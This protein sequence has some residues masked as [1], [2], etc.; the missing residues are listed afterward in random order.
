MS[1]STFKELR[2]AGEDEGSETGFM[3]RYGSC[4][5][6]P[7][8]PW[9]PATARELEYVYED[10][11]MHHRVG[12]FQVYYREPYKLN[13]DIAVAEATE[14]DHPTHYTSHPSG[15]ECIEITEHMNFNLGN[16]MKY[17]WRAGLKGKR[18]TDLKKA[19]FYINREIARIQG[20][21][22]G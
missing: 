20:A 8:G 5:K 14:V 3:V 9:V 6:K 1:L 21:N 15:V 17:I 22:N 19:I 18:L 7:D 2:E 16:A 13:A 11:G 10:S 12:M 4:G